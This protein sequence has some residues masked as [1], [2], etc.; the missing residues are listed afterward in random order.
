MPD[1]KPVTKWLWPADPDQ[2]SGWDRLLRHFC[3]F[4]YI[5]FEEFKRD[6]I[7]LRSAALTYSIVLSLVPM[8]AL[9]TAVLKGMGAGDQMRQAAYRLID[10]LSDKVHTDAAEPGQ[11]KVAVAPAPGDSEK[12]VATEESTAG[13][14][15]LSENL[16]PGSSEKA[17][18]KADEKVE[19]SGPDFTAHLYDAVDRIFDYVDRTNFAA[20]GMIGTFMLLIAV[21]L[22]INGIEE[23]MNAIWRV[24]QKRSPGRKLMN[25]M[26]LLII[27]PLTVNLG[28]GATTMLSTP[29]IARH[30][31]T[32][33]PLA[34]LQGL[35]F[36]LVPL[37][38]LSLTFVMLYQFLPNTRVRPRAAWTGGVVAALG[39]MALQ[40]VFIVLQIGVSK[41][42]AIYGSFAT[43]PLFLLWLNSAWLV[44]LM[45]A[46]IAF[47]AQH[48]LNYHPNGRYLPPGVE[49]A[50][51]LD[52]IREIYRHFEER[53]PLTLEGLARATRESTIVLERI[54]RRLVR[55]EMI[56]VTDDQPENYLP[57]TAPEQLTV[58]EVCLLFWGRP[59]QL[60]VTGGRRLSETFLEAGTRALPE[61]PWTET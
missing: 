32:L 45:G 57:A 52:V 19:R 49:L 26:A 4:L 28:I 12:G 46:E 38:L 20:L 29:A 33:I 42:N 37:F 6:R 47:T 58:E 15:S 3:R 59:S 55:A 16:P 39:L 36:K 31:D 25:Y 7:S 22:V 21:L 50:L 2:L 23:A 9:S 48:Y 17:D 41:Y 30:I 18:E 51:I 8:L 24:E 14:S 60:V 34:W 54:L 13:D 5:F 56:R 40:K 35:I 1:S 27:C 11:K 61:H 10:N 53:R 44:F 43:V